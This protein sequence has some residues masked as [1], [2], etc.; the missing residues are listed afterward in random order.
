MTA[1]KGMSNTRFSRVEGSSVIELR[2]GI[3]VRSS[4]SC[5]TASRPEIRLSD[6]LRIRR[7]TVNTSHPLITQLPM[8]G[9]TKKFPSPHKIFDIKMK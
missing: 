4:S 5:E 7:D 8:I 3:H 1:M 9:K 6:A 2:G